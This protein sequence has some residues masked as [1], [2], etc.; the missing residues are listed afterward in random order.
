MRRLRRAGLFGGMA[1]SL[2]LVLAACGGSPTG[3]SAHIYPGLF[4][5][6]VVGNETYVTVSN[7]YNEI[8][9]LPLA[10]AHCGKYGRSAR[11]NHM[12]RIRAIFDCVPRR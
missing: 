7:V 8:D 3:E 10:E 12:E 6:N 1:R 11:F 9:A 5:Q 4:G 2:P